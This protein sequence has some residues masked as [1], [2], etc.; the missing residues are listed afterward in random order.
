[1]T[2]KLFPGRPNYTGPTAGLFA[3]LHHC[4]LYEYSDNVIERINYVKSQKPKDE[5]ELRLHHMLYLDSSDTLIGKAYSFEERY[6]QKRVQLDNEYEH[7]C[8]RLD[9]DF[10]F[11]GYNYDYWRQR[12]TLN[13]VYRQRVNKLDDDYWRR[14]ALFEKV[15]LDYINRHIPEHRWNGERIVFD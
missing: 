5:I 2:N 4:T 9:S 7:E 14:R 12:N 1:M 11:R 8:A 3:F 10:Q 15:V 6:R 13:A